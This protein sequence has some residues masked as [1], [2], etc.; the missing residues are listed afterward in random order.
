MREDSIFLMKLGTCFH[1]FAYINVFFM[2]YK[3]NS[4]VAIKNSI[5]APCYYYQV[6]VFLAV[7]LLFKNY[8]SIRI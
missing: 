8:I 7:E 2:L 1:T 6:N 3:F 5:N 4:K